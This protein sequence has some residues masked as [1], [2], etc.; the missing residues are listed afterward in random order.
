LCGRP[1][2]GHINWKLEEKMALMQ[3]EW[4]RTD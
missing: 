4:V 1:M 2:M 3:N